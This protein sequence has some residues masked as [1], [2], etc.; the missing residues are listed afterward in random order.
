MKFGKL[1]GWGI[2]IYAIMQLAWSALVVYGLAGSIMGRFVEL[3]VL[4]AVALIAS[5][6]LRFHTWQDIFPY[7]LSWAFVVLLLD[8]LLNVP[9]S[10]WQMY[11]DW[12]LWLGYALVVVVPLVAP[13]VKLHPEMPDIT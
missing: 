7:S 8:A 1:L 10:G 6:T 5:R 13:H 2:V 4:V 9:I 12:N 11:G 3:A